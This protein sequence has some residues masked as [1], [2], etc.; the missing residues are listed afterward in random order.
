MT[1]L[2]KRLISSPVVPLVQTNAPDTACDI[3][4]ALA[5]GGLTVA[6]VVLRTPA[7]LNCLESIAKTV[8]ETIVGAGTVLTREQC[9]D[10]INAG[11][12]FIV[13]PGLDDNVVRT[14]QD[15]GIPVFPGTATA[16]EVQHALNLGLKTVKFFPAGL[17]GGTSMLK[18]LASV[19]REIRFMPTGGISASNL[20]DYLRL[21]S[22]IACGGSWL[23]PAA[24]ISSGDFAEITRLAREAVAI[25]KS[26][27]GV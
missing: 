10:A 25:A 13:S 22:V 2:E 9:R 17:A 18:A 7:A 20:E 16:T 24:A 5:V 14:A 6:E 27:R 19:Y 12:R 1:E 11:A 21:S 15:D 8:P 23:T 3:T 4:R 26:V